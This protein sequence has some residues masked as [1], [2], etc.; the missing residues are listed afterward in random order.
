MEKE[1]RV[2]CATAEVLPSL[3]DQ[4]L[5]NACYERIKDSINFDQRAELQSIII[6]LNGQLDKQK[7][8]EKSILQEIAFSLEGHKWNCIIEL[9]QFILMQGGANADASGE[10]L[11]QFRAQKFS[12]EL[13]LEKV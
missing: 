9:L 7:V 4:V 13:C 1:F 10:F 8:K 3:L 2:L 12:L 6:V 11:E 5:N